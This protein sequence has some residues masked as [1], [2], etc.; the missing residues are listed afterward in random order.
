MAD[1]MPSSLEARR[2]IELRMFSLDHQTHQWQARGRRDDG[3]T[4]ANCKVTIYRE[5]SDAEHCESARDR[6]E[7]KL[8]ARD[9]ALL[10]GRSDG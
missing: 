1:R 7:R 3:Y 4:C 2:A 9:L 8:L 10:E 6:Y 5:P